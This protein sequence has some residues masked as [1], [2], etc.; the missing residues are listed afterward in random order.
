M[1]FPLI[2]PF[3]A[4]SLL[5]AGCEQKPAQITSSSPAPSSTSTQAAE[6]PDYSAV[7]ATSV[8]EA[9]PSPQ[10]SSSASQSALPARPVFKSEAATQAASQYLDS[11]QSLLDDAN[12]APNRS[13]ITANGG[14]FDVRPY[15]QKLARDSA[16]LSNQQKQVDAQLTSEEKKRLRQYQKS[17]DRG[18]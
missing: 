1:K 4:V 2:A 9:A 13:E 15:A 18:E 8:E 5:C 10:A 17:L 14:V 6:A 7:T 16:A 12:A 11:Y 3:A